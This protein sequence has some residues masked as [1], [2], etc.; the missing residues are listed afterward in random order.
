[1]FCLICCYLFDFSRSDFLIS[2]GA[3][4]PLS[5]R[6][7]QPPINC[8]NVA[9]R[10]PTI[11]ELNIMPINKEVLPPPSYYYVFLNCGNLFLRLLYNHVVRA[12]LHD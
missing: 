9:R 3:S 7:T 6:S 8:R 5:N 12:T 4:A 11:S 10:V 2:F 1:M